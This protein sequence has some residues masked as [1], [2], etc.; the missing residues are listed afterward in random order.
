MVARRSIVVLVLLVILL[1]TGCESTESSNP[2]VENSVINLSSWDFSNNGNVSL[3]GDWALYWDESFRTEESS[4]TVP[5]G[6]FYVPAYWTKY[7]KQFPSNGFATYY[8]K[9]KTDGVEKSYG[10]RM[11]EIYTEYALWV[12]GKL[13]DACGSFSNQTSNYLHPKICDFYSNSDEIEIAIQIK[14]NAHV[15]GGIGQSVRLGRSEEIY[16]EWIFDVIV[17][18]IMVSVC[19]FAGLYHLILYLFRKKSPELM[20][21]FVLCVAVVLR[22]LFSNSTVI[23]QAFPDMP[24]WIGSKLITLSV[25]IIAISLMFYMYQ[26]FKDEMPKLPYKILLSV[27]FLYVLIIIFSSSEVYSSLFSYYLTIVGSACVILGMYVSVKAIR[28][29]LKDSI[30]IFLGMIVISIGAL[31]D[32]LS[33]MQIIAI[34][35]V[36]SVALFGFIMLQVVLLAKRYAEA[37]RHTELLSSDLQLSLDKLMNT[38]VAFMGAQM[39]PHFLYNALTTIS[40]KCETD[41]KEAGKLIISLSKYLRSTLDYDNWKGKVSLKKELNL[42]YAYTSIEQARFA[43][44]DV[45]IVMPEPLPLIMLPPLTLQPLLENAI[46]H[47]LRKRRD[48]GKVV[49]KAKN[50]E[51][52]I[53]FFVQDNGVGIAD[54]HIR[55]IVTEPNGSTSI[56]LYNIHMR[57]KKIYGNGL[58]IESRKGIGTSVSFEVP[59]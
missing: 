31:L 48:G 43:N 38:E 50:M 55:N 20:W 23:M 25:P 36:F 39:K 3:N 34:N 30:Y 6:Y 58:I 17:D 57:L 44:V 8:V 49:L 14:N 42:V 51:N 41:A 13:I 4:N 5:T 19:L 54:E 27:N 53:L 40:E 46:K 21:F 7:Q 22:N 28:K 1:F 29:K 9:V 59:F 33:Y 26:L 11:P 32:S 15:Y 18:I 45:E 10:L 37:F 16:K 52:S 2:V 56:G 12:N 24:F 47:G 35:Y